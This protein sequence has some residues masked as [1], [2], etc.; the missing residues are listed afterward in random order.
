M[1]Q[2]LL[3]LA[4]ASLLVP[5]VPAR[6]QQGSVQVS[7]SAQALT[8]DPQRLAGQDRFEPDVGVSWLQPGTRFG[9]FQMEI[10]STRRGDEAHLGRAYMAIRDVNYAGVAWSFEGGDTYFSPAIGDYRLSNL[11][12]PAVTFTG[13]AVTGR[14]KQS[15]LQ[16]VVGRAA[17]WRNIFGSD[18]ET[19]DQ[20]IA[21]ARVTH[22]PI[23]RLEVSARASRIRT[24]DLKEFSFSIDASDQ[25]GGGARI[26]L[27]PELQLVGDASIVSFRRT[28]ASTRERDLSYLA[29]ANW[30][31]KRGWLQVN[32]SHF[33]PGE[34][35]VLNYPL[36]DR[37]GLFA[38]GDYDLLPRVRVS[39]GWEAFRLNVNPEASLASP[40]PAPRSTGQREFAGI[41]LMITSRSSITLRGEQGDRLSRPVRFGSYQDSDTGS[42]TAEWQTAVGRFNSFARYSRRENVDHVNATSSYTQHDSSAQLFMN[43]SR[44]AQLFGTV[45][46]MRNEFEGGGT[47]YWQA[48][49][50]AQMKALRR[51]LWFR[52]EGT[53]ARNVD[54]LTQ[55][56]VPRESM[57]LGLNGQLTRRTSISF[58]VNLDRTPMPFSTGSPWMTRSIVRLV[59][60][61]P[62]GSVYSANSGA[63]TASTPGRGT[64]SVVGSVFADWNANG[65]LDAGENP[66]EGI[67]LRIVGGG[68][69]SSGHDGQFAFLNVP[70]GLRDVGLDAAAIPID[71]DP[72]IV[73]SVQMEISR[74]DT[75]RVAFG[76]VPLGAIEGRV[77]RDTNKNSKAD[78]GEE[79]VE[80]AVI[81]LDGGARSEQVRRGRY[82]FDAVRS[83]Q[84]V[85]KLLLES[86]PE[87][88][89]I[90]GDAETKTAL[91]RDRLL[92]DVSFVIS[93]EKRPEIRKV[94]PPKGGTAASRATG[95]SPSR[96]TA[97]RPPASTP[98]PRAAAPTPAPRGLSR[99]PAVRPASTAR[100]PALYAIQVAALTDVDNAREIVIRLSVSGLPAY[101]VEPGVGD[102]LYRVRV[103]P[104]RTI[105]SAQE[106]ATKLE[107][108]LGFK[109]WVTRER[110]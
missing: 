105:E 6:A 110:P 54:L 83:G 53:V 46:L 43:V 108:L 23:D 74:G 70:V 100:A 5:A 32:A 15:S 27:T 68:A 1:R 10:R 104:Y 39:G 11:F 41:R 51:D 55:N 103:G 9:I 37:E 75:R 17:A 88:A 97:T 96:A 2:L 93:V 91:T 38:A 34:F 106:T 24:R 99:P 16:L 33:A 63:L 60:S 89:V 78:P 20:D 66:L 107:S 3:G 57:S 101:L 31:H 98:A 72:P 59:R 81:I 21:L 18:P 12:T 86:L 50:G 48:G 52:G 61:L 82:R 80:S 40:R 47:T 62:T 45:M 30:L 84:H 76:L 29:G 79:P 56:F 90:T 85:V 92:A 44:S 13:G 36:Q 49:G 19:L 58:N 8:G 71:F 42:W 22:K 65:V 73:T 109:L 67:P 4:A 28:G 95:A 35:P 87:G 94:F 7:A 77:I 64:G 25:A 69:T 102:S 14:T 26:W